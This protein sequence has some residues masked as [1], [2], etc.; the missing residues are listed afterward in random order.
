MSKLSD[1]LTIIK[2]QRFWVPLGEDGESKY[3][4]V[5]VSKE[6]SRYD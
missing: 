5:T 2:K 6:N 4:V 3:A 1:I